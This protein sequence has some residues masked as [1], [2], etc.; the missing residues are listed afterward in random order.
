MDLKPCPFCGGEAYTR[1]RKDEDLA[2]HNIVDWN[3]VGCM[4]CDV[5]F[6]IPDGY[7]CG[8]AT[9]QW[10]TR[11]YDARI[12]DLERQLA[13]AQARSPSVEEAARVLGKS[14]PARE[15]AFEAMWKVATETY[16]L[17]ATN[18]AGA[19]YS[20]T[21]DVVNT[22]WYAALRALGETQP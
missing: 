1:T 2:T 16:S 4:N 22:L 18:E 19:R 12:A 7:D 15:A 17:E 20:I 5:S 6:E 9:E 10:N 11:S 14:K 3:F 8:T 13:E 21:G